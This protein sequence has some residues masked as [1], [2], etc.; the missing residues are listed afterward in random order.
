MIAWKRE[1]THLI[2]IMEKFYVEK[3]F[4]AEYQILEHLLLPR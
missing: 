2:F 3:K 4:S 1:I